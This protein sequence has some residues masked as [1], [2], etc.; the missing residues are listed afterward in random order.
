MLFLLFPVV[1]VL[2]CL[3]EYILVV[4]AF[5]IV[6]CLAVVS[7]ISIL[8]LWCLAIRGRVAYSCLMMFTMMML[9]MLL[10]FLGFLFHSGFWLPFQLQYPRRALPGSDPTW[11]QGEPPNFLQACRDKI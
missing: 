2:Y 10:H 5:L 9:L 6:M 8:F 4:I 11:S 7:Q 3:F 1:D